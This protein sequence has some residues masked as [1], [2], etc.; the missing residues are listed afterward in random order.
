MG[1]AP[2]VTLFARANNVFD[3]NYQLAAGF[4]HRRRD[5]VRRAAVACCDERA[6]RALVVVALRRGAPRRARR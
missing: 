4:A 5:G 2:G 1:V 6:P 3:K